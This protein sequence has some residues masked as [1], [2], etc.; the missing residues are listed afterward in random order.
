MLGSASLATMR[1][2]IVTNTTHSSCVALEEVETPLPNRSSGNPE[3]ASALCWH[4][5]QPENATR[6]SCSPG[7]SPSTA[8][9]SLVVRG[10]KRHG[11]VKQPAHS[12]T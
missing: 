2:K 10:T 3:R 1:K 5:R 8:I 7:G 12:G 9:S 4:L 11:E 6:R